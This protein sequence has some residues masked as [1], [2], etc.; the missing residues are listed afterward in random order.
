MHVILQAN[1]LQD[2]FIHILN[3]D[4]YCMVQK[5][6]LNGDFNGMVR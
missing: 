1:I 5:L 4:S 6:T 3:L 2:L